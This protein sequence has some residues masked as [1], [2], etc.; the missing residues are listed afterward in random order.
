MTFDLQGSI[1][2]D[3]V[4][5]LDPPSVVVRLDDRLLYQ[6]YLTSL[7]AIPISGQLEQGDHV[8]AVDF[9]NKTD[10]DTDIERGLDKAVVI[11]S[12]DFFGITDPRFIWAGR[13]RPVYNQHWVAEQKAKGTSP[14]A[15]LAPHTYLGW[16]GTWQLDF[17][18]P[19]FTWIHK[20]QSLGWIYA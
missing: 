9:C 1:T 16:N 18:V 13:Y 10:Q 6:D 15:V 20:T 12:L 17:S 5:W 19:I 11:K 2:L 3:P 4:W 7:E 14:A 8:L